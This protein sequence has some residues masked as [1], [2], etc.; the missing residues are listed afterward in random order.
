MRSTL[1]DRQ[2]L[3]GNMLPDK[4][5]LIIERDNL[6]LSLHE[7]RMKSTQLEM[8]ISSSSEVVIGRPVIE[9]KQDPMQIAWKK[10][11]KSIVET[12]D[13][14]SKL[15]STKQNEDKMRVQLAELRS[16]NKLLN[17]DLDKTRRMS[18]VLFEELSQQVVQM[19]RGVVLSTDDEE[20]SED[21]EDDSDEPLAVRLRRVFPE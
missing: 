2:S 1:D 5:D 3:P 7:L 6:Q 9:D 21:E 17:R 14:Q 16:E 4:Q 11:G 8:N 20:S 19:D 18:A 13:L 15:S 12:K 10:L